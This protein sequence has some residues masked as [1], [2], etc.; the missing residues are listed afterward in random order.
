MKFRMGVIGYGKRG[1]SVTREILLRMKDVQVIAICDSY[2]DRVREGIADVGKK[3]GK[4]ANGYTDYREMLEKEALDGVYIAAAWEYHAEIALE[5][6]RRGVPVALEVGGAYSIESLW[7]MVRT[8]EETGTPVMLMENC[9]FGKDELLVTSMVRGGV[10]GE[11]VH[12][13]GAYGHYLCEEIAGGD[14]NRHYRLRNYLTRNCENY[15]THELGPIAK[16]LN[17]NRGNRMVSLVSVA[18][19]AAGMEEYIRQHAEEYPELVGKNFR[20]GDIVNTVI[21]CADG[22]TISL[23]LDTTL[24]RSYSRELTVRGTKGM[25]EQSNNYV[26]L[27]G[28]E[29]GWE[30]AEHYRKYNNNAAA[31]EERYLPPVWKNITQEQIEAG[32]GGMDAI[33]FRVFADCL[34]NGEEFPIDVYD[35]A[36]WMSITALSEASVAAGGMPQS[37]PDFTNGKWTRRAPRD[38]TQI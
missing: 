35:A 25:Y 7:R 23:R 30:P 18:S 14:R 6:M 29:E 27:A 10:F 1:S 32:H 4:P 2:E 36:A 20:Q 24:P 8:Q 26:F 15:P 38:V 3:E 33:E 34:R 28:D 31:Y 22:S 16:I 5:A 9:C 11:I 13:H 19:R 37:V 12:C 17:I 21:T